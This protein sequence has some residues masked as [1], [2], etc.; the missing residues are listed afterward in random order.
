MMTPAAFTP[1]HKNTHVYESH[2]LALVELL[3]LG[4]CVS[5]W[6]GQGSSSFLSQVEEHPQGTAL[7][8]ESIKQYLCHSCHSPSLVTFVAKQRHFEIIVKLRKARVIYAQ[9]KMEREM[10][11][12]SFWSCLTLIEGF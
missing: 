6:L 2:P 11:G 9:L 10:C 5:G 7:H 12:M 3:L 1:A 4:T 8:T